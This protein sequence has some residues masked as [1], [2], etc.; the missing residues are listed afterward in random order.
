M[1]CV[2]LINYNICVHGNEVTCH[3]SDSVAHWSFGQQC[4]PVGLR[5][6]HTTEKSRVP[7]ASSFKGILCCYKYRQNKMQHQLVHL[8]LC[9]SCLLVHPCDQAHD[10]SEGVVCCSDPWPQPLHQR[11]PLC[12]TGRGLLRSKESTKTVMLRPLLLHPAFSLSCSCY[13]FWD[14]KGK[15]INGAA[16]CPTFPG[17][18]RKKE[19]EK[20]KMPE[21]ERE[22]DGEFP[23]MPPPP[24]GLLC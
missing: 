1:V 11:L 22:R 21:T 4:S 8:Y 15:T 9:N 18:G 14:I 23:R 10:L 6:P 7:L 2:G 20:E 19:G 16:G 13:C 12:K 24:T 5:I 17:K 3:Q